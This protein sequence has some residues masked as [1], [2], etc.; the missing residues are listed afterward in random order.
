MEKKLENK[1][2]TDLRITKTR[3]A[4]RH[5]FAAMICEMDYEQVTIKELTARAQINRKTFYFHYPTLDAL[6]GQ[7]QDELVEGF[8]KRT[9]SFKGLSDIA[10][11]IREFFLYTTDHEWLKERILC[12]GSY[13]FVSDKVVKR[14]VFLNKDR[15]TNLDLDTYTE[16]IVIT[17]LTSS[18][19]E[20]Y[21]QWVADGR[22]IPID[23]MIKIASQ[24]ISYGVANLKK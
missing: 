3:R 1:Q 21:R 7:M 17:F 11:L 16:K 4:I 9:S 14:I 19:L 2:R 24:L 22:K 18:A 6:L 12:S 10:A 15:K 20:M 5:T 13:R 8:I 23:E